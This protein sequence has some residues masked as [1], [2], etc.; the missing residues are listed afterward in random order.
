M[1]LRCPECGAKEDEIVNGM[2]SGPEPAIRRR[3]EV[4]EC[5]KCGFVG[6]VL[7]DENG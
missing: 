3:G 7:G 2:F 1:L 6:V 4:V 5:I